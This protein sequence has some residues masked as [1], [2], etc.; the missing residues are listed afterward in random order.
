VAVEVWG[1][2]VVAVE[3]LERVTHQFCPTFKDVLLLLPCTNTIQGVGF[4]V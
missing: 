3:G 1:L 2:E 4:R